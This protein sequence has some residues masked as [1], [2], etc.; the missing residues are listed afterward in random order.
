MEKE[1]SGNK[2]ILNI[3]NFTDEGY[4]FIRFNEKEYKSV[5]GGSL[6]HLTGN[7]YLLKADEEKVTINL[8]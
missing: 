7:L 5:E 2:L 8:K 4:F 6:T 1:Y 3:G